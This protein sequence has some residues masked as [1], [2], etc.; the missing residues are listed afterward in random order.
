M[1]LESFST[2]TVEENSAR[3]VLMPLAGKQRWHDDW[4]IRQF[5]VHT[6]HFYK[7]IFL[8]GGEN[9][10]WE[11]SYKLIFA[12]SYNKNTWHYMMENFDHNETVP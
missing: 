6:W 7:T 11:M 1:N 5:Y 8:N 4:S 10:L 2:V 9:P 12:E 3:G